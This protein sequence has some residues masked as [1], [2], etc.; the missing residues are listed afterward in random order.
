MGLHTN[1]FK[2][3]EIEESY[4]AQKAAAPEIDSGAGSWSYFMSQLLNPVQEPAP[5]ADLVPGPQ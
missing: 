3:F 5:D 2:L 4:S 1:Q